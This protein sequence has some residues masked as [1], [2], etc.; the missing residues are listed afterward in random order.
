MVAGAAAPPFPTIPVNLPKDGEP[1]VAP[2]EVMVQ[3]QTTPAGAAAAAA[4]LTGTGAQL[5]G[6]QL[7][8]MV[9]RH[10]AVP[11]SQLKAAG[12]KGGA[13]TAAA[14]AALA[15]RKGIMEPCTNLA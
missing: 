9:G 2:D 13:A 5:P 8:R 10:R 15:S 11:V 4:Q 14:L 12:G 6:L 7:Q 1:L 3:F